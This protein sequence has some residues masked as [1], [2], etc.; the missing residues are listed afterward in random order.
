MV[1]LLLVTLSTL[2]SS[3]YVGYYP[4]RGRG[5]YNRGYHQR[6]YPHH[7]HHYRGW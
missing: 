1:T 5:Y 6:H 7:Y 4:S 2:L 3:C